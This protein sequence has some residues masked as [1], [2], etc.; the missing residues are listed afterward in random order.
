MHARIVIMKENVYYFLATDSSDVK[1]LFKT[2]FGD[3][4]ILFDDIQAQHSAQKVDGRIADIV[5]GAA[6]NDWMVTGEST[7]GALIPGDFH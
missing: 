5:L 6:A 2:W 1:K 4:L 3:K 7:F